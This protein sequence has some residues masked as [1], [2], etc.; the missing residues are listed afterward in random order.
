MKNKPLSI[1]LASHYSRKEEIK[2]VA[3]ALTQIGVVITSTWIHE[4]AK[5]QSQL[6][7][8][9]R[10]SLRKNGN[11]DLK[12]I[13]KAEW[14]VLFSVSPTVKFTRGGSVYENGYAHGIGKKCFVVGPEQNIFHILYKRKQKFSD[15]TK[16]FEF[17]KTEQ[18]RRGYNVGK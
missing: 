8:V 13:R 15:F 6:G 17:V 14:L 5:S 2:A 10:Q 18:K 7:D 12:E 3:T 4:R 11:R 16:F 1:Y 9:S